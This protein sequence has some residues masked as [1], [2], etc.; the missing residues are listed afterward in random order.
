[1][2]LPSVFISVHHFNLQGGVM[3]LTSY[4]N[5]LRQVESLKQETCNLQQELQDNSSHLT[6]LETDACTMKSVLSHIDTAMEDNETVC[7]TCSETSSIHGDLLSVDNYQHTQKRAALENSTD[8]LDQ[9]S[10]ASAG[11]CLG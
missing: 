6:K 7:D 1:M 9:N 4:D 8:S 2:K 10:N 5:L 11:E 3:S